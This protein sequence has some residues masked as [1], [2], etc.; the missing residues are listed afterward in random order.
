MQLKEF[1]RSSFYKQNDN[2]RFCKMPGIFC[3]RYLYFNRLE[4]IK[5][6]INQI[7]PNL[8]IYSAGDLPEADLF[9]YGYCA[10]FTTDF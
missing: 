4:G 1:M 3:W 7:L 9:T 6:V 8:E 5:L 10:Y 2:A